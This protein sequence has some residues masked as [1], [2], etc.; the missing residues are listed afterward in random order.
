MQEGK[1]E[2]ELTT[3]ILE[4]V[5]CICYGIRHGETVIADVSTDRAQVEALV[6]QMND[7]A[8]SPIHMADVVEDFVAQSS[9]F[10]SDENDGE[11]EQCRV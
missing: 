9:D 3:V 11:A 8:V 6:A 2:L 5:R 1:Y 10:F 7:C 4:G